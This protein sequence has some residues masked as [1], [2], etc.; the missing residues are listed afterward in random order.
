MTTVLLR[1]G[2]VHTPADPDATA[3]AI[4]DGRI[5]WLGGE[6]GIAAAGDV[7]RV[8]DLDGLLVVPGFVD[9]HVHATDGGLAL[10]GLDLSSCRSLPELLDAVRAAAGTGDGVLW[11]T[12]WDE[13]DWPERRGP[14]TAELDEA[15]GRRPVHLSRVDVHSA[16]AGSALRAAVPGLADADG[17]SPDGPLTRH[18]HHLVRAAAKRLL[19]AE[20]RAQA[21]RAFLVDAAAHGVVAVHECG[22]DDPAGLDDLQALLALDG[23]IPVR[24]YLA[25]LVDDPEQARSLLERTGAHALGGDL[26]VD[27]ALG[28]HTAALHTPYADAAGRGARYLTEEQITA[29]LV[30]CARAG[31]Q[32]GFHAIGEDAVAAVAAALTRAA[33][34]L[35]GT[36]G[37][38]AVT[39]RVE[40][41]EMIDAAGIAALA[42]TGTVASVQPV[43]DEL[44]GGTGGL[45]ARRVGDRAAAMNPFGA[46]AS[47]GV[48]LAFGSDAPVTPVDPWRAVRAAVR[49]RTPGAGISA[50]AAF[51]AHTR[52]GR[53]A[54][55]ET[56]RSSGS[57]TVGA[58]ADL[59]VVSAGE[60][61]RPPADPAVARWSTDPRSRVPLLPDLTDG[62]LP[63]TVT[64]L[65]AGT[66][67]FDTGLFG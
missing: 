20:L 66:P 61:V 58:A 41:A 9:A 29:H 11:G 43:F 1:G 32:P 56:D 12:G 35:G 30:A 59:A 42:A 22:F 26:T 52:G 14:S 5:S 65:V 62:D 6:H 48:A 33:E 57:I 28:S 4:T 7:D 54:A 10:T 24:G 39:P 49:H 16:V 53:R 60:L 45:Y 31:V 15:A 2:R 34:I 46:L 3:L 8:I 40:H 51:T 38:A 19:P 55:G 37:L 13:S 27:G 18:A 23:P 63:R 21:Q 44:W 50:R 25:A 36:I 17:F 47:A 64:T 67:V